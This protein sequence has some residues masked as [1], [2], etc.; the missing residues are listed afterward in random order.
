MASHSR[1]FELGYRDCTAW[2]DDIRCC[3]CWR[4]QKYFNLS[5]ANYMFSHDRYESKTQERQD[6]HWL[7]VSATRQLTRHQIEDFQTAFGNFDIEMEN[8]WAT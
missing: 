6:M 1:C 5:W 8:S 4:G 3:L 7:M 2:E